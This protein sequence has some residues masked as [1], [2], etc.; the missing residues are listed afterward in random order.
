VQESQL[1]PAFAA[2]H[3][4]VTRSTQPKGCVFEAAIR[5]FVQVGHIVPSQY[6]ALCRRYDI[7][8]IKCVDFRNRP[9]L[10]RKDINQ[11]TEERTHGR[12]RD[13]IPMGIVDRDTSLLLL[14]ASYT[15]LHFLQ[16]FDKKK[17][18]C[19]PFYLPVEAPQIQMMY[20]RCQMKLAFQ[21]KLDCDI[22]ELP[23]SNVHTKFYILLP[24]K[25]DGV[26]RMEMKLSR[27]VLESVLTPGKMREELVDLYLPK[28][29][30]ELGIICW[31]ALVKLG[32]KNLYSSGKADFSGLG[33]SGSLFLSRVFHHVCFELDEGQSDAVPA[34][35]ATDS[36]AACMVSNDGKQQIPKVFRADHPFA[37]CL[38][39]ERT[40]AILFIGR[41]VRPLQLTGVE[42]G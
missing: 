3:W 28:F 25:P 35:S 2:M 7:T 40:G 39:D 20:Q 12:I 32:V 22:L 42:V 23:L 18:V 27:S 10:A 11:W 5:L 8:R 9:D 41:V 37:F 1:L 17:T 19:C 21:A 36:N 14:C 15:K 38:M 13:V 6:E 24:R 31:D 4:D 33:G 30:Y 29:R 26:A 16:P 34:F